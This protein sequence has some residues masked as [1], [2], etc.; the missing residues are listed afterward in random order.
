MMHSNDSRDAAGR[1]V[2]KLELLTHL[3]EE[4][5]IEST[6]KQRIAPR[7]TLDDLP[8]S[9]AQQ[10]LWFLAQLEPESPVYNMPAAYR[11]R[12]P[13]HVSALEQTLS[14]IVRRHEALRTT[15]MAVDGQPFQLVAPYRPLKLPVVDLRGLPNGAK[16]ARARQLAAED[17]QRPF[18]LAQGPLFRAT[19]A[20]LADE[21]YVFLLNMHHIVSDGW[22][23]RVLF[24][25]LATL[26]ESFAIGNPSPLP[27][28]PIQYADYA[29]WQR[30]WLQGEVLASQLA[31]WQQQLGGNPPRLEL[32]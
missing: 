8:L 2:E 27:E 14:E 6:Q 10:R 16:E 1:F 17:A 28:L 15:F 9:F 19:L 30:Q 4:E 21:E 3:L 25:E 18:D 26:Y 23:F 32:P 20:R 22:S 29:V 13:L 7:G 11:L 31:Y 5:G 24:R 12:G